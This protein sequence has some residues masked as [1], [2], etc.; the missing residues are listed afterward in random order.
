M[1]INDDHL[2]HGAAL[3]QIAEH[4]SFT[5]INSLR[6]AS[7]S[8]HRTAY[9]INNDTGVFLKYAMSPNKSGVYV[10]NFQRHFLRELK[11]IDAAH[12]D[13][14]VILVCVKDR[15]ICCL[16]FDQV[17][18]LFTKLGKAQ[19]GR[20]RQYTIQVSVEPNK[21]LHAFTYD[22]R[23]KGKKLDDVPVARKAF[24]GVIFT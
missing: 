17:M 9:T 3:I 18:M 13:T 2:Y 1:K 15:I 21:Q 7:G 23:S 6:T 8:L 14:F 12:E 19:S 22:P 20:R 16:H 4:S 11:A 24:P 10:F 5:A